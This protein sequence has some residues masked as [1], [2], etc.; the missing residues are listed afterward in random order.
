MTALLA[1]F[2]HVICNPAEPS[3]RNDIALTE[4]VVGFFGRLEFLTSG[5]T[6][7]T[8]TGEIVRQARIAVDHVWQNHTSP[9]ADAPPLGAVQMDENSH[10]G[11]ENEV[12][13]EPPLDYSTLEC[14]TFDSFPTGPRSDQQIPFG[15]EDLMDF[16]TR[17]SFLE[18]GTDAF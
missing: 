15:F 7:F 6:A 1:V 16:D 2:A 9:T 8:K 4:V 18:D 13:P 11:L 5:V 12:L 3:A 10:M 14:S 17:F